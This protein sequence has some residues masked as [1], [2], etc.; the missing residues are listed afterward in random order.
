M[1]GLAYVFIPQRFE[2]LQAELDRA[3]AAFRRGGKDDLPRES[4]AFFDET[5]RLARLHR[6]KFRYDPNGRFTE[7]DR[8]V[9]LYL[10]YSNVAQHLNACR[11]DRFEGT[12]A[13]IE[14]DFDKFVS[15]FTDC[16]DR[17]PDTG[18]YGDG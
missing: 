7:L 17:E 10:H 11:L 13:E 5:E 2:S 9:S 3:L 15:E 6:S 12:F 16:V 1:F 4:L 18:R 8:D 14:P